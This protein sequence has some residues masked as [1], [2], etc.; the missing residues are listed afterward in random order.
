MCVLASALRIP[1]SWKVCDWH[2]KPGR[3][4]FARVP[5]MIAHAGYTFVVYG[6]TTF[7]VD[8]HRPLALVSTIVLR[9]ISS[10]SSQTIYCA[11]YLSF[12]WRSH[13][14][15]EM[16]GMLFALQQLEVFLITDCI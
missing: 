9:V 7:R 6:K 10:F 12:I 4:L 11:T 8:S 1:M 2:A 3:S 5:R 16:N 13:Q 14:S 15:T